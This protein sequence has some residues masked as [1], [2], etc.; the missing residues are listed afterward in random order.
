MQCRPESSRFVTYESFDDYNDGGYSVTATAYV[1]ENFVKRLFNI[2]D[3]SKPVTNL[4][5]CTLNL[6]DAPE[7]FNN[8][9]T[10][11]DGDMDPFQVP[12]F[13]SMQ[14][15]DAEALLNDEVIKPGYWNSD[16]GHNFK[17]K[18][19]KEAD[20][21]NFES[22]TGKTCFKGLEGIEDYAGAT[23]LTAL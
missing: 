10:E 2:E 7:V 11:F 14:H 6:Y 20:F 18:I 8:D 5:D 17:F 16:R 12:R 4:D 15:K 9:G 3:I 19:I 1:C 13:P 21:T 23:F 22:A